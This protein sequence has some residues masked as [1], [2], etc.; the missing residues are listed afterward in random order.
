MAQLLRFHIFVFIY[1][2]S[3]EEALQDMPLQRDSYAN[4][5]LLLL[6]MAK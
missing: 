2:D 3:E 4:G 1:W 5:K 6:L